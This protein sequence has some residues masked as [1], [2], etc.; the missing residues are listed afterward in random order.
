MCPAFSDIQPLYDIHH[1]SK[2]GLIG[3]GDAMNIV[4]VAR[5]LSTWPDFI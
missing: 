3:L 4:M 5:L 1:N 2:V